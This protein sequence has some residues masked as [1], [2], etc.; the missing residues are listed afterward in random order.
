MQK[1]LDHKDHLLQLM[2]KLNLIAQ[3]DEQTHDGDYLVPGMLTE[4]PANPPKKDDYKSTSDLCITTSDD[5]LPVGVFQRL[6]AGCVSNPK[7]KISRQ[8]GSYLIY[9]GYGCF[10]IDTV[11]RMTLYFSAC[12][13]QMWVSYLGTKLPGPN[14]ELCAEVREYV[15]TNIAEN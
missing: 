1:F 11:H 8:D 3:I 13:I 2:K 12:T 5:F 15:L 4:A 9:C 6:L 10:E 14:P 7:W